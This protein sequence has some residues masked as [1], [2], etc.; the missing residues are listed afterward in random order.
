M[1]G[2]PGCDR[3][4]RW[5]RIPRRVLGFFLA[6]LALVSGLVAAPGPVASVAPAPRPPGSV[7]PGS[8]GPGAV[9]PRPRILCTK[10]TAPVDLELLVLE[11]GS[12][13]ER[14]TVVLAASPPAAGRLD[15]DLGLPESLTLVEGATADSSASD[16][17]PRL[18]Q[19]S[20]DLPPGGVHRLVGRA[21]WRLG[22]GPSWT[23]GVTLDLPL[24]VSR[25]P[26]TGPPLT[27]L[28]GGGVR[29]DL[30]GEARP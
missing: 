7:G 23:R 9:A 21:R 8:V 12:P 15:L 3:T 25:A 17:G 24:G 10:A 6:S 20:F 22:E 1:A 29:I 4:S 16:G 18:L 2:V 30:Q 28:P 13:G 27:H 5:P 11:G 14:T 26:E 19:V